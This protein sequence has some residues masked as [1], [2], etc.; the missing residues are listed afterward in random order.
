MA[1]PGSRRSRGLDVRPTDASSGLEVEVVDVRLVEPEGG[2]EDDGAVLADRVRLV[3]IEA[4]DGERLALG[5]L[6]L[7]ADELF[8]DLLR[9]VAEVRDAP[10]PEP[11]GGAV[12][13]ERLHV[14]REAESGDLDAVALLGGGHD[15]G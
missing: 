11:R 10:P 14:V 12:R 3:A 1:S 8:G 15:L 7:A 9:E 2:P 4:L 5:A 6:D 13:H